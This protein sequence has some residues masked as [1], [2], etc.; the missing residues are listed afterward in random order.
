MARLDR[1]LR[2]T[3]PELKVLAAKKHVGFH[4]F[5]TSNAF[6]VYIIEDGVPSFNAWVFKDVEHEAYNAENL[7]DWTTHYLPN[8][9]GPTKPRDHDGRDKMQPVTASQ[10][11]WHTWNSHGD[12]STTIGEGAFLGKAHATSGWSTPVEWGYRDP[13]WIVG[14]ELKYQG[15]VLGDLVDF[16]IFAPPTPI[17]PNNENTGNCNVI[18]G[19]IVPAANDGAYDVDLSTAVVVPTQTG[20]GGYWDY[21]MPVNMSGH[22][23]VVMSEPG[24]G[25]YHLIPARFNLT[26]FVIKEALLG[27]GTESYEP[28]N[29]N[30]SPCLPCWRFECKFFNVDGAHEIQAIWRVSNTRYW[31][32]V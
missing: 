28:A 21:L 30:P 8:A 14:G 26:R 13:I 3:W 7:T 5:E 31:T 12:S 24:K 16:T 23:T 29:P 1:K 2:V 18:F 27:A 20:T 25:A 32:T 15:A 6:E 4:S 10:G 11:Q 17:V 19:V 9:N 22:G